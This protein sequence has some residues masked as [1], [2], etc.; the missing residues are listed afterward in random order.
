MA[1]YTVLYDACV[2]YPAP[3][4]DLLMRVATTGTFKARWTNQIHDEWISALL[5]KNSKKYKKKALLKVKNMMNEHVYDAVIEDYEDLIEILDLPDPSDRHVLAA[6]IKGKCDLI[7]TSNLKDF[8]KK[9]LD[10]WGIE[11]QH[12]DDFLWHL[13]DLHP[14]IVA[15]AAKMQRQALKNP[16]YSVEDFLDNLEANGLVKTLTELRKYSSLI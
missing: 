1:R 14:E 8:P 3:L 11:A 2:L 5:N 6:A 13:M 10:R 4:R 16:P 9:S 7:V 15:N 12:P